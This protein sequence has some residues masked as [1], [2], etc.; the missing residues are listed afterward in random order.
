MDQFASMLQIMIL[1]ASLAVWGRVFERVATGNT[2]ISRPVPA[3]RPRPMLAVFLAV[4]WILVSCVSQLLQADDS[5]PVERFDEAQALLLL[6]FN[7][8]V[9]IT[10]TCVL[11]VCLTRVGRQQLTRFGI[12]GRNPALYIGIGFLGYLAAVVPVAAAIAAMSSFRGDDNQHVFLQILQSQQSVPLVVLLIA[13]AVI[14][15]PLEEELLYRV[16][17]QGTLQRSM[18]PTASI[19]ISASVFSAVHGFP[20]ALGLFPLALV[21][22]FLYWRTGSYLTIVTTHAAFNGVTVFFT[23]LSPQG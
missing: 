8:L 12:D 13:S 4:A 16:I 2:L 1:F 14:M 9:Q 19:L 22:G 23:L 17:F 21:L 18:S 15:A 20:D 5:K 6:V 3:T 10:T 11:L 7:L